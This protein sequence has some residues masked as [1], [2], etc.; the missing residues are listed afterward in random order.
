LSS[1]SGA[2][3]TAS[4]GKSGMPFPERVGMRSVNLRGY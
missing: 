3:P 4:G 1:I 2:T